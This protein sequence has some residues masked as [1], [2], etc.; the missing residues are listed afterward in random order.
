MVTDLRSIGAG[1]ALVGG[2]A[3][4]IR[5]EPRLTRDV[6]IAISVSDDEEARA[7]VTTLSAKGYRPDTFIE[8]D[9][10]SRLAAVR[11]THTGRPE[12]IIDLLF[13][14]GGIEVEIVEE[15]EDIEVLR[16]LVHG[17]ERG[18]AD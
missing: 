15:A 18:R 16:R 10:S 1:F 17:E 2:L 5:A 14:S 7:V 4:S 12:L 6:D 11:L 13:A 8:H 3:V 9:I